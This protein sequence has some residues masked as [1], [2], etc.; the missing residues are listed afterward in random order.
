MNLT[1]VL[2]KKDLTWRWNEPAQPS[3]ST[4]KPAARLA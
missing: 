3:S 2:V 1:V 4:T